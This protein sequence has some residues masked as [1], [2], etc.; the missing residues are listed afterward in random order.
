MRWQ[1]AGRILINGKVAK[2]SQAV[3]AGDVYSKLPLATG[4]SRCGCCRMCKKPEPKMWH[5]KRYS[6]SLPNDPFNAR[7][8]LFKRRHG[9]YLRDIR[10]QRPVQCWWNGRLRQAADAEQAVC[11]AKKRTQGKKE[12]QHG[13]TK[14]DR[15]PGPAQVFYLESRSRLTVT[16]VRRVLRCDEDGAAIETVREIPAPA[17]SGLSVVSLDLDAGEV[18]LAGRLD[19]VGIYRTPHPG[20]PAAPSDGR[21]MGLV[22]PQQAAQEAAACLLLVAAGG[23]RVLAPLKKKQALLPD[24]A[25]TG[26]VLYWCRGMPQGKALGDSCAGICWRQRWSV[27]WQCRGYWDLWRRRCGLSWPGRWCRRQ[28]GQR[29][30]DRSGARGAGSGQNEPKNAGT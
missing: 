3:A 27:C 17:G 22:S 11:T 8:V 18:R 10:H 29:G 19:A 9:H 26:V 20:R 7:L 21:L 23:L 1:Y 28:D 4:P 13:K 30:K 2:A 25:L 6:S 5:G 16:G 15:C 14:P 24:V 12:I